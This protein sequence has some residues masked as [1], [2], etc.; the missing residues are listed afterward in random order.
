MPDPDPEPDSFSPLFCLILL[1]H[2]AMWMRLRFLSAAIRHISFARTIQMRLDLV[3]VPVWHRMN[4]FE[5][6][7]NERFSSTC[8]SIG[9]VCF[10]FPP[11]PATNTYAQTLYWFDIDYRQMHEMAMNVINSRTWHYSR[12]GMVIALSHLKCCLS[13]T[14]QCVHR[15]HHQLFPKTSFTPAAPLLRPPRPSIPLGSVLRF[16]SSI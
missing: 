16:E 5:Y 15:F 10:V 7:N 8:E 2:K 6:N 3:M 1:V 9:V 13:I 4:C 11:P 14:Q 12:P